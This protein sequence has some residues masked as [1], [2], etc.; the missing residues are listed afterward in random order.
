M[1]RSSFHHISIQETCLNNVCGTKQV[2]IRTI[3]SSQQQRYNSLSTVTHD[4]YMKKCDFSPSSLTATYL[5]SL[6]HYPIVNSHSV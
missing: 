5:L 3:S 6:L 1:Q 2:K 4:V